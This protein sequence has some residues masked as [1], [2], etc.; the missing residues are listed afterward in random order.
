MFKSFLVCVVCLTVVLSAALAEERPFSVGFV[1]ALSGPW[2]EF[3]EA[4]KNALE[5]ARLEAPALFSGIKFI[6]EDGAHQPALSLSAYRK[7]KSQD[8]VNIVFVWGVQP[9]EILAPLA[10]QDKLP[11]L[12][13]AQAASV[14]RQRKYVIRTINYSEQYSQKLL[15]FA[16]HENKHRLALVIAQMSFYELLAEGLKNNLADGESLTVLESVTPETSDFRTTITKAKQGKFDWL[17]L[18]LAP[19]QILAFLA[20][21]SQQEFHPQYFGATPFQS[22][23]LIQQANG[24]LENSIYVHNIVTADFKSR[25]S[26]HFGNDHQI[27]WAA[28]AYDTAS[29]I[30]RLFSDSN[31]ALSG[32]EIIQR[33][34]SVSGGS[35]A[36]GP[37]VL[38]N[39]P[40][41][42]RYLEYPLAVYRVVAGKHLAVWQ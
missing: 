37:Y 41:T 10:E 6:Y 42:G 15:E 1:L 32:E 18:Y 11:L 36:G 39:L 22:D 5:L 21:A 12:V 28:N 4:Q 7:L 20:Q 31:A 35:G 19:P 3:G 40:E 14:A 26:A 23:S 33:I 16:R 8:Q 17:G 27:P 25:Y 29:L 2:A 24:A 30:G 34:S 13:S 9:A 38:R